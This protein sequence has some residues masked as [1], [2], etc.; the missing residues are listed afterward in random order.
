MR[1]RRAPR[2][3]KALQV[4][5]WQALRKIVRRARDLVREK[6]VPLLPALMERANPGAYADA[7]P[8]G[9]RA[10][11]VI[12]AIKRQMARETRQERVEKVPR[13]ISKL[14]AAHNERQL[15]L[16]G[17]KVNPARGTSKAIAQFTA[18]NV[19]LIRNVNSRYLEEVEAAVHRAMA[20]GER[21]ETL[22]KEIGE[23]GAV[24]ENRAKII[25][26]DQVLRFSG[27]LNRV[28]QQS[29]GITHY[30]WRSV[31]DQRVRNAHADFDGGLYSWAEGAGDGS[32]EEGI[33]PGSAINCRCYADP[34]L[35]EDEQ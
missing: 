10:Q 34:V 7:L 13:A 1:R 26:R 21:H 9:K 28:R 19:A 14:V 11:H 5:Y 15:A 2:E 25:A 12:E 31:E 16:Q 29:A 33:H 18:E 32:P 23:R 22:A 30:Y 24:A 17:I 6:L 3:P 35:P 27:S 20:A 8:P 4:A